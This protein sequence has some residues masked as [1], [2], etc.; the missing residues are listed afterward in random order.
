MLWRRAR[1]LRLAIALAAISALSSALLVIFIFMA[2]LWG[3]GSGW[4]IVVLFTIAL[5]SLIVALVLFI[6]DINKSLAALKVELDYSQ[7]VSS[8][9]D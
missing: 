7:E 6:N 2:A 4:F 8:Q 1:N 5:I 3:Y 9:E